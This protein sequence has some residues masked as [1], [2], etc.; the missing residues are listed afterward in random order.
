[1]K[2][3]ECLE[4]IE[5]EINFKPTHSAI[6]KILDCKPNALVNR[7]A[8]DGNIKDDEIHKIELHY[9]IELNNKSDCV[10]LNF[11]SSVF[12]SCGNGC[13]VFDETS[14][15]ISVAKNMIKDYSQNNKYS[16][17][18]ARGSSMAP[19]I[20][21][22]D[23]V[24]IRHWNGEQIVDDNVYL[25]RYND[26]LFL[27]RLVKNIDQIVCISENPRFEDRIIKDL[28]NFNIIGKV[29]GL[30]REKV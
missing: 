1:M 13:V 19:A 8:R 22:D 16:V 23:K 14:E 15:K 12:A 27:K 9:G 26:E 28:K 4:L 20:N 11:Y 10:E 24:I 2:Y 25:F 29:V 30:F 7:S 3:N 5:K 18:S 17:I 21:D 6:A